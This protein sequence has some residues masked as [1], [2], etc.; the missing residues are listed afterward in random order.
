MFLFRKGVISFSGYKIKLFISER[1][2]LLEKSDLRV[3]TFSNEFCDLQLSPAT[4]P[5]SIKS[6]FCTSIDLYFE[7]IFIVL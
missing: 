7:S 5:S 6:N 4:W 3:D 1:Y 2:K